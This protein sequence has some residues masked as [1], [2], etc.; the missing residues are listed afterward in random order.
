MKPEPPSV[1]EGAYLNE[2]YGP[3]QTGVSVA[4]TDDDGK[5]VGVISAETLFEHL[6][7]D[8]E[9]SPSE[10]D[11]TEKTDEPGSS[12]SGEEQQQERRPQ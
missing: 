6:V 11:E 8:E 4:V 1:N 7:G 9:T 10:K 5:L 2:L 3:A 12:A